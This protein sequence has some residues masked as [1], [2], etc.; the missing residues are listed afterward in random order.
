M[1]RLSDELVET[2][3]A[4]SAA[5]SW[6]E[7]CDLISVRPEV[8]QTRCL[9]YLTDLMATA[10]ASGEAE[11]YLVA[12]F[13]RTLLERCRSRGV[14]ESRAELPRLIPIGPGGEVTMSRATFARL[15]E[16]LTEEFV[17]ITHR[18][19]LD[20]PVDA[21][22]VAA[23]ADG[24]LAMS[25]GS[26]SNLLLH[27]AAAT[28]WR[29]L[30]QTDIAAVAGHRAREHLQT[31]LSIVD[32][33][34]DPATF[35][36]LQ[37]EL[38]LMLLDLP[39]GDQVGQLQ[40][41]MTAFEA[42]LEVRP[43]EAVPVKW[44]ASMNNLAMAL[45]RFRTHDWVQRT[46]RAIAYF[47]AALKVLTRAGAVVETFRVHLNL[48]TAHDKL[49]SVDKSHAD[50]AVEAY[51]AALALA[52]SDVPVREQA[53]C[54][55]SRA[56]T[57]RAK[58]AAADSCHDAEAVLALITPQSSPRMVAAA[59]E[60]MADAY[61]D[62]WPE[63]GAEALRA[64]IAH[65]KH[66][67]Q[68]V[69]VNE[70]PDIR[71]RVDRGLGDA[72][73]LTGDFESARDSYQLALSA[74]ETLYQGAVEESGRLQ[75]SGTV[76]GLFDRD[77]Y[78]HLKCGRFETGLLRLESG[79]ARW[80]TTRLALDHVE[81]G[82]LDPELRNTF[83]ALRVQ[84]AALQIESRANPMG[85]GPTQRMELAEASR[86][87]SHLLTEVHANNRAALPQ[88]LT[89]ADFRATI[90]GGGA[91]VYLLVTPAGGAALVVPHGVE[92]LGE[93]NVVWLDKLT[94]A[95]VDAMLRG[96]HGWFPSYVGTDD[97]WQQAIVDTGARLWELA[98]GSLHVQLVD[99]GLDADAP[100]VL[101]PPGDL[102]VL[103]LHSAWRLEAGKAQAFADHWT[104]SYVPSG[105]ALSISGLRAQR[106]EG[107]GLLIVANPTGDLPGTL[108]EADAAQA[109]VQPVER[110]E[111]DATRQAV[112]DGMPGKRYVHFACH[113]SYDW[114]DPLQSTLHLAAGTGVTLADVLGTADLAQARL[115]VLSAC[116]TALIDLG[117]S[118]DDYVGFPAGFLQA[119]APAVLS[120]LWP[121]DDEATA[122]LIEQFYYAHVCEEQPPAVALRTAVRRLRDLPE[123]RDPYF[124]AAFI[125]TGV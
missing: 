90:P 29:H 94:N 43:R 64:A 105:F 86:H 32:V 11:A 107:Q 85:L 50:R 17:D 46:E 18:S 74:H 6:E 5:P 89:L 120:T 114:T 14:T 54:L 45:T 76:A 34:S 58:G 67:S 122:A 98:M 23:W 66:A 68:A 15:D 2:I 30:M 93:E 28:A 31:A 96:A 119:G 42:A 116:E 24:T 27:Q 99:L 79:R 7:K 91:L 108:D 110:L 87:M 16:L 4:V 20:D 115:V 55:L 47:E 95:A 62:R 53:L 33:D 78:A 84:I 111:S 109:L 60:I 83:S 103:P 88:A 12:L 9:L 82:L 70:E 81:L 106:A 39:G 21:R 75:E 35:G 97:Q 57:L 49:T 3:L 36:D 48:G 8:M 22:Y 118:P 104:V 61:A 13:T 26:G 102:A 71:R 1:S 65:Y 101:V 37:T 113:G 77:A 72:Y 123:Y 124:W 100:I 41:A 125:V 38:G 69:G 121:V 40:D 52:S 73:L 10:R 25:D 51:S 44:A 19:N 117:Q 59:H 80:T 56:D 112:I 63:D 92:A